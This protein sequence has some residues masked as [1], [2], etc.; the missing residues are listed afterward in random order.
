[1]SVNPLAI[2]KRHAGHGSEAH[3]VLLVHSRCVAE[4]A[5]A[6]AARVSH[7]GPDLAFIEEASLLH[8]IGSVKTWA[9]G[10][11]CRGEAPYI[12]HGLLGAEMLRA[13]GLLAHARVAERHTGAGLTAQEI[14]SADL[15]LPHLDL[16]PETLEEKIICYADK[17]FSKN[18]DT[19]TQE[20]SLEKVFRLMARYGESQVKRFQ[21]LADL[22]EE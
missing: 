13:E 18:P 12:Q 22:F 19:L 2:L 10:I 21:E 14:A 9:P 7:L 16:L 5:L 4:K 20:K 1:M 3:E 15:P 8:D 11:G 17:F 6:I